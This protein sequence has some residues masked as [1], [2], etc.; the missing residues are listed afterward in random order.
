MSVTIDQLRAAIQ[1]KRDSGARDLPTAQEHARLLRQ[2][3]AP[4]I[5]QMTAN[6][7]AVLAAS[8]NTSGLAASIDRIKDIAAGE[9]SKLAA[10]LKG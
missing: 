1:E 7:G 4:L 8:I 2:V 9:I 3:F 6:Y 5:E 10:D